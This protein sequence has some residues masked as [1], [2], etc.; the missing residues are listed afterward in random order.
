M[1]PAWARRFTRPILGGPDDSLQRK[2]YRAYRRGAAVSRNRP[3]NN[4]QLPLRFGRHLPERVVELL[5]ARLSY[6]PG[7]R[8]LDVGHANIMECHRRL[9]LSLPEPRH[10]TGIDIADPVYDTRPLY[11]RSIKA[12]ITN[13]ML[14]ECSFD[15]IWCI[16]T[17]EH[18]GMDNS[19]DTTAF[20][21]GEHMAAQAI[22]EMVRLTAPGG[23]LLITV[24]YGKFEDHG[25]LLNIDQERWQYLLA[26]ARPYATV[27]E[28]YF[29]HS[30]ETGWSFAE[31]DA[32]RSVGY[33]DQ[34]NAGAAAIAVAYLT[35]MGREP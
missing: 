23:H 11:E 21:T 8:V 9:L 5:L 19:G 16:S 14:P 35:K 22:R 7:S 6:A 29:S 30:P 28:S 2:I 17:L 33:Y 13:T 27:H 32:L 4:P 20:A 34:K 18:V 25:W 26:V 1:I 24:P 12:D 10:L 15:L 31:P 3:V